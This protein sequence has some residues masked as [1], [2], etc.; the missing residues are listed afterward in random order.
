MVLAEVLSV[1]LF[2]STLLLGGRWALLAP[3]ALGF[4]SALSHPVTVAMGQDLMPDRLSLSSA[5][6]MGI[7]WVFGSLGVALTGVL[8]DLIGMQTSLLT[9]TVVPLV[10]MVGMFALRWKMRAPGAVTA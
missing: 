2:A 5:L 10:G 7:S 1:P 3:A 8:G 6:T 9:V 4:V